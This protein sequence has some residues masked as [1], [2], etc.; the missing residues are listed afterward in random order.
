MEVIREGS[1][2]DIQEGDPVVIRMADDAV[3]SPNGGVA[4]WDVWMA[5]SDRP[6]TLTKG[7]R[8]RVVEDVHPQN[9]HLTFRRI[10]PVSH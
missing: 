5:Q 7:D 9:N 4:R 10:E 8:A 1:I 3:W 6:K 2:E